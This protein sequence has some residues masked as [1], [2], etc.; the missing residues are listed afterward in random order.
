M[1]RR[2]RGERLAKM[3]PWCPRASQPLHGCVGKASDS[4]ASAPKEARVRD[5]IPQAWPSV[6]TH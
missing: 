3:H 2:H 5:P 4:E 1:T 6:I